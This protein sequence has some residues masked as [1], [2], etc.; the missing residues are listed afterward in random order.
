MFELTEVIYTS[1]VMLVASTVVSTVAFGMGMV[2]IPFLILALDLQT[3]V[4]MVNVFGVGVFATI[5]IQEWKTIQ[6]RENFPFLIA[7]VSGV[8]IGIAVLTSLNQ[9]ILRTSVALLILALATVVAITPKNRRRIPTSVGIAI[10]ILVGATT[11]SLGI[12]GPLG[13]IFF[14]S[15]YPDR[16]MMRASLSLFH[17]TIMSIAVV[18]YGFINILTVERVVLIAGMSI[19]VIIGFCLA[20]YLTKR[21]NNDLFRKGVIITI[22][23]T[24][25]ITLG[26]EVSAL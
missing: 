3:A 7:G 22:M 18:G 2:A 25:L 16:Y 19:P 5:V 10:S 17:L 8:P 23:V 11:T 6:Y 13:A 4:V 26:N 24:S 12:G 1:M 20:G 14:L 21:L 9:G 15:R